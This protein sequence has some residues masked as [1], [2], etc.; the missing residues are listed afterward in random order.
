MLIEVLGWVGS[1]CIIVAYMLNLNKKLA[2]DSAAYYGLNIVGSALL[3]VNTAWHHAY[4][5][6]AINIV[7]VIIPVVTIVRS[8]MQA[9]RKAR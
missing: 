9:G 7:W 4:P 1:V 3:I 8:K 6:M 2:V 5:S